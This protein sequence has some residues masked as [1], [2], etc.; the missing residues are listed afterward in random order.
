[1]ANLLKLTLMIFFLFFLMNNAKSYQQVDEEDIVQG[2]TPENEV[3][4]NYNSQKKGN[5]LEEG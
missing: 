5:S 1:M 2:S 3:Q 4:Y